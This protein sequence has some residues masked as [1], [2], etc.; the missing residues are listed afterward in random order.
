MQIKNNNNK[1]VKK[2]LTFIHDT[3]DSSRKQGMIID[4]FLKFE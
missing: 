4:S 3:E 1:N 2:T